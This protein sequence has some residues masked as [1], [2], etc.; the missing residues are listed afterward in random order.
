MKIKLFKKNPTVGLPEVSKLIDS[1]RD[2]ET[3]RNTVFWNKKNYI[4]G[5]MDSL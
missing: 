1:A 5:K 2:K 3:E 4:K